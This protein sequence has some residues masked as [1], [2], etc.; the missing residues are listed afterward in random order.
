MIEVD[1]WYQ[2]KSKSGHR[3]FK[4]PTKP[5]RVTIAGKASDDLAPKTFESILKQAGLDK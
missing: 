4:Y 1:G 2:V 5:G 3:Q